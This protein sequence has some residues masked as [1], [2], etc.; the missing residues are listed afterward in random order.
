MV[1]LLNAPKEMHP[2][3]HLFC[4]SRSN[5]SSRVQRATLTPKWVPFLGCQWG[6]F[7]VTCPVVAK[8]TSF[9]L[10]DVQQVSEKVA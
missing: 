7:L 9:E 6:T 2:R 8:P 10:T 5:S 3:P 1:V 4:W